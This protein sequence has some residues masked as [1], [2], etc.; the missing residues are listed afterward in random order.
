MIPDLINRLY[1]TES[2]TKNQYESLS[3]LKKN[4]NEKF[5]NFLVDGGYIT[6][7]Q[8]KTFF[9]ENEDYLLRYI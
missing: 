2:I 7:K 1:E 5:G 9:I 3:P 4:Y 8:L 6:K